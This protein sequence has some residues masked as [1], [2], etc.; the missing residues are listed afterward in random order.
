MKKIKKYFL[1]NVVIHGI[2]AG[3]LDLCSGHV[4]SGEPPIYAMTRE[5]LEE[6]GIE[7]EPS[8]LNN[9]GMVKV[10]YNS[11]TDETNRRNMRCITYLYGCKISSPEQ[12]KIDKQE[13]VRHRMVIF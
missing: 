1:K 5:L 8:K 10:D 4:K 13:V 6:L 12:I 9:L 3:R 7:I 2:D 11:L